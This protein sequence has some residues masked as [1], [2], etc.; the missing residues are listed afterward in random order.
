MREHLHDIIE[1][2]LTRRVYK[3]H[4]KETPFARHFGPPGTT[5][6]LG[7]WFAT[8]ARVVNSGSLPLKLHAHVLRFLQLPMS[9]D[10]EAKARAI[11]S[12]S[13]Q[14]HESQKISPMFMEC[15]T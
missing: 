12:S 2:A 10:G 7:A 14:A 6:R 5:A 11:R 9:L 3:E 1:A 4:F 15:P 8:L 13:E